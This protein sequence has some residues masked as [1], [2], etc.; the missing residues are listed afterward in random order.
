MSPSAVMRRETPGPQ[1]ARMFPA[2]N[3]AR[4]NRG[5]EN[6]FREKTTIASSIPVFPYGDTAANFVV[7]SSLR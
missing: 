2:A 1:L 7:P 4:G 5:L 3:V 6:P